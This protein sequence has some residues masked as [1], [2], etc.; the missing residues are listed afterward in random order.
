MSAKAGYRSDGASGAMDI[1]SLGWWVHDMLCDR[2][3]W[4]DGTPCTN[5]EASTVLADILRDEG[6]WARSLYWWG[7][8]WLLGGGKARD[9]GMW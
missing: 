4:D 6:R 2:G 5:W 3:T 9:N 7:A 1:R 8:T